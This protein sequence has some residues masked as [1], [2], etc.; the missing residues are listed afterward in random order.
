[1]IE[2]QRRRHFAGILFVFASFL[3]G[4]ATNPSSNQRP[5]KE[6]RIQASVF[7]K[8]IQQKSLDLEWKKQP[9]LSQFERVLP[10]DRP[11]HV[12][13]ELNCQLTESGHF[14]SC[15]VPSSYPAGQRYKEV[16]QRLPR[17]FVARTDNLPGGVANVWFVILSVQLSDGSW[18][19]PCWPPF[20]VS[21][22]PP[23]RIKTCPDGSYVLA[24]EPC[25]PVTKPS[26]S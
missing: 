3:W 7:L 1:M 23:P 10:S 20:C 2:R 18:G 6:V 5:M 15:E 9:T 16:A 4:C 13:F 8:A 19:G 24:R 22:P 11:G 21:M 25:P 26:K 17:F 14:R 12:N